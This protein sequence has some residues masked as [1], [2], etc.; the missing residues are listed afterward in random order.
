MALT[1]TIGSYVMGPHDDQSKWVSWEN[2]ISTT[3][4]DGSHTAQTMSRFPGNSVIRHVTQTVDKNFSPMDGM[5]RF[6]VDEVYQGTLIRRVVGD[7]V[8]SLVMLP[9]GSPIDE[10]SFSL[11]DGDLMLGYHPT[12]V[13]G[14]KFMKADRTNPEPQT[15]RLLSS[16]ATWNGSTIGHGKEISFQVQYLGPEEID[17]RIGRVTG[18]RYLWL[19]GYPGGDIDFWTIGKDEICARVI[20]HHKGV[21]YELDTY[22]VTE[23]GS[24]REFDF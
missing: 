4:P 3:N 11:G 22:E 24:E 21:T 2:F 14:W 16:S 12:A 5:T 13:E 7:T 20:S 15:V 1:R 17:L 23:F 9:D 10:A 19:T 18:H 8:T 6:F